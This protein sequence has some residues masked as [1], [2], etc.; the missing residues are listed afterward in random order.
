MKK[1]SLFIVMTLF[2]SGCV[3]DT[4]MQKA[5]VA[6]E[7]IHWNEGHVLMQVNQRVVSKFRY[8]D[9]YRLYTTSEQAAFL[10]ANAAS[11]E[12][13]INQQ[14]TEQIQF[15]VI[16]VQELEGDQ[17]YTLLMTIDPHYATLDEQ[18]DRITEIELFYQKKSFLYFKHIPISVGESTGQF[19]LSGG[20]RENGSDESSLAIQNVSSSTYEIESLFIE[21]VDGKRYTFLEKPFTFEPNMQLLIPLT[22]ELMNQQNMQGIVT[23]NAVLTSGVELFL[24]T[25]PAQ[26]TKQAD[27]EQLNEFI[28]NL[29]AP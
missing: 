18:I 3:F 29:I 26:T 27:D 21:D 22:T 7:A 10:L 2:L 12:A 25:A 6:D 24:T 13:K 14:E 9:V 16:D 17:L 4:S 20:H 5:Y 8:Q 28:R 15:D 23:I 11:I 19:V 1:I